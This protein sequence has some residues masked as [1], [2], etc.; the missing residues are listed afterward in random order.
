MT[1]NLKRLKKHWDR[2]GWPAI[3][4]AVVAI[5]VWLL[6]R[7]VRDLSLEELGDSLA[8]IPPTG[9]VLS[10]LSALVAY[11]ALAGYDALAL[12]HLK[13][14]INWLFIT[15][16]SFTTYALSHNI[17]ASV[18]SG[19]VIR[20]RAYS[21]KGLAPLEIGQLI[22]FC[23]FTF[24]LGTVLLSGLVLLIE[25]EIGARFI[26]GLSVDAARTA[27]ALV[28]ALVAAYVY[29]SWRGFRP[30]KVG[31]MII[32]YPRLRTVA[33][34]LVIGPL[35]L[36]GAAAIIYFALPAAGNPGYFTVLGIFLM[37]FSAALISSAPGGLGVLELLFVA[38][39][40]DMNASDV[41]AALLVFRLFYLIIP[42]AL[43]LVVVLL[44]ERANL[45]TK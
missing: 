28:L 32:R 16:T 34:Q 31:R 2:W 15:V 17:G 6:F 36:L 20:Y 35:E 26:D 23:S 44:F 11:A 25:P 10:L 22:A 29:G 14:R 38:G 5:S 42:F 21:L 1:E 45:A 13:R 24:A 37:S 40:D 12:K 4:L 39:L 41:L 19:S 7:E 27:G 33:L 8:A 30:L 43:S 18:L 3:G 9:W